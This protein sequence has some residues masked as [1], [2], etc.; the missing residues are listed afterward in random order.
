MFLND[1]KDNV[2]EETIFQ[3][4]QSHGKIDEC[5][6][7]AELIERYDTVIVHYIN[8]QDHV[9]A[10]QKVTEI[11]EK[12]KRHETM[13]RYA[14]IFVNKCARET[15]AELK[16]K[17]YSDIEIPKLMP[18]FMNIREGDDMKMALDYITNYCINKKNCKSKTVHNM[19]FF[20][21]SK[22]NDAKRII[23]FLENEEIKKSKGHKIYFEVDYALN[24]CKQNEKR[25][26]DKLEPL[27]LSM[28]GKKK[29]ENA[30]SIE[31]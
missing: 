6:E 7:Y 4:L 25:L 1:H 15:I 16:K 11:K 29:T 31:N 8:K 9:R 3:V 5:I 13:L 20:F 10:L 21:H 28:A 26:M 22:I 18:A 12:V 17:E 14:S 2:N 27:Q 23:E 19:A 24:I 30:N